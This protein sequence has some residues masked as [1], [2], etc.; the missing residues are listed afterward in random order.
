MIRPQ[1]VQKNHIVSKKLDRA[2]ARQL[3]KGTSK[4]FHPLDV[5]Q[6]PSSD[7]C[8]EGNTHSRSQLLAFRFS[9]DD[10][11]VI[12]DTLAA[13]PTDETT[14]PILPMAT[15]K[16]ETASPILPLATL[17]QEKVETSIL[18][19]ATTKHE[20]VEETG[21]EPPMVSEI[22]AVRSEIKRK[23]SED[24]VPDDWEQHAIASTPTNVPDDWEDH[25][26]AGAQTPKCSS[27]D[28]MPGS[29]LATAHNPIDI[30]LEQ[31]STSS[32][33]EALLDV[34]SKGSAGCHSRLRKDLINLNKAVS[35]WIKKE[36]A[37]EMSENQVI[38][39]IRDSK[40]VRTLR[41][42]HGTLF[43]EDEFIQKLYVQRD[44]AALEPAAVPAARVLER[45]SSGP[46]RSRA[47]RCG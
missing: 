45:K 28:M 18:P 24:N 44:A 43:R 5:I 2:S 26:S 34:G 11:D 19:M 37:G 36:K 7:P 10:N 33:L 46:R 23:S 39:T 12:A 32:S 8:A 25:A 20:L 41:D 1:R 22:C 21:M 35:K 38:A 40:V 27:F 16:Q 3:D 13:V 42:L 47:H 30:S 17:K 29:S 6:E 14:N 4:D 15:L 31:E 9:V